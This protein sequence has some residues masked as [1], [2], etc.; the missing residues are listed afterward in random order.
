MPPRSSAQNIQPRPNINQ[1]QNQNQGGDLAA[2]SNWKRRNDAAPF[3]TITTISEPD[4]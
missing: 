1:T 3:N 2:P 4:M